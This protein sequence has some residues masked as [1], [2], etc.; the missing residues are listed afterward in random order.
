VKVK[1]AR[2][3]LEQEEA[4]KLIDQDAVQEEAIRRAEQDASSS[5]TRLTRLRAAAAVPAP[6]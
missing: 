2:K 4:D 1:E 5:S 3:I 6:T